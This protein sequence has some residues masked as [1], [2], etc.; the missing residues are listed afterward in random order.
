MYVTNCGESKADRG[1]RQGTRHSTPKFMSVEA[2]LHAAP[3][4]THFPVI[5]AIF[6]QKIG[7]VTYFSYIYLNLKDGL[8]H[9]NVYQ[10]PFALC[11]KPGEGEGEASEQE[12]KRANSAVPCSKCS[13][14]N[15]PQ[16]REY[17]GDR[18][19]PEGRIT[20]LSLCL[21]FRP[22][23]ARRTTAT[24]DLASWGGVP[25]AW[26]RAPEVLINRGQ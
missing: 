4:G 20:Q 18:V 10:I 21:H 24:H 7:K 25:G 26:G 14:P 13:L 8:A 19:S 11:A 23:R 3:Q 22:G 5:A 6:C 2:A 16:I 15:L 17:L 1:Q 12:E 9:F